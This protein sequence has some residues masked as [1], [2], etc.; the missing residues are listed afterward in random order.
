MVPD[1]SD[2]YIERLDKE[3]EEVLA[4]EVAAFLDQPITYFKNHQNEFMYLE[5]NLFEQIQVDA[6]SFE[7]DDVFGTYGLLLGL[8]VQKKHQ[9]TIKEFFEAN[10]L[11]E[12]AKVSLMFNGDDGLW[13]L[14]FSLNNL[15][16][17]QEDLSI[18]E[19]YRLVYEFLSRLVETV[20]G[21]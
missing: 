11:G 7:V 8:K 14:N 10:L 18:G 20:K 1:F 4:K 21:H 5:S 17:F 3:T 12:D 13:D 6:I 16:G 9:P 19:A 15:D 2:A